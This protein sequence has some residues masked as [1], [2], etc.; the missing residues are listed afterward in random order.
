MLIIKWGIGSTCVEAHPFRPYKDFIT[1]MD[2]EPTMYTLG[3]IA[4]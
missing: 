2:H 4:T 1:G 3:S